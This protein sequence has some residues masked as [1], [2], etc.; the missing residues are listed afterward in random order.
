MDLTEDDEG[1]ANTE[2]GKQFFTYFGLEA[3]AYDEELFQVGEIDREKKRGNGDKRRGKR[4]KG[5]GERAR[6]KRGK[7]EKEA[8]KERKGKRG[9]EKENRGKREKGKGEK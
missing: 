7:W 1:D 8:G 5:R 9:S 2:R 6:R 3:A 4:A